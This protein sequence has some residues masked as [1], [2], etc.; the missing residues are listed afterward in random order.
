MKTVSLCRMRTIKQCVE[1]IRKLDSDTAVTE[2]FVRCLCKE[3]KIKHFMSGNKTIVNLD[4]LLRYLNFEV[5]IVSY[6]AFDR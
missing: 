2:W 6:G 5:E 3:N 4:D 1:E